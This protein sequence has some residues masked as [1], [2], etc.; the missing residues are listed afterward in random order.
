MRALV[1]LIP[2]FL[3]AADLVSVPNPV[4]LMLEFRP[5]A[6]GASSRGLSVS[7]SGYTRATTRLPVSSRGLGFIRQV[8]YTT[9]VGA[10]PNCVTRAEAPTPARRLSSLPGA[11]ESDLRYRRVVLQ[12]VWPGVDV[13]YEV[14]G[15]HGRLTFLLESAASAQEILLDNWAFPAFPPG[16]PDEFRLFAEDV[17]ATLRG[18]AVTPYGAVD[19]PVVSR[20]GTF[21]LPANP[22]GPVR[23]ILEADFP[24]RYD[25]A[26]PSALARDGSLYEVEGSLLRKYSPAGALVYESA[27][28]N[29]SVSQLI[30]GETI[31]LFGTT[32]GDTF[33]HARV[34][35]HTGR[36]LS[37]MT[38][39]AISGSIRQA[40]RDDSGRLRLIVDT[41]SPS[42]PRR[43]TQLDSSCVPYTSTNIRFPSRRCRFAVTITA[44]GDL[45]ASQQLPENALGQFTSDGTLFWVPPFPARVL[46]R[47]AAGGVSRIPLLSSPGYFVMAPGSGGALWFF[48]GGR[49]YRV[50]SGGEKVLEVSGVAGVQDIAPDGGG[51][52]VVMATSVASPGP[53]ALMDAP[54]TGQSSALAHIDAV[55]AVRYATYLPELVSRPSV[56]ALP[57]I[58]GRKILWR[59]QTLDPDAP[60]RPAIA[61]T[62]ALQE[63][64]PGGIGFLEVRGVP[65]ESPFYT[66][67]A[68]LETIPTNVRGWSVRIDGVPAPILEL[69][70]TR[71]TVIVPTS[72]PSAPL[73]RNG[74]LEFFYQDQ[75]A[76]SA[77]VRLVP[78]APRLLTGRL[79]LFDYTISNQFGPLTATTNWPTAGEEVRLFVDGSGPTPPRIFYTTG[80]SIPASSFYPPPG[81]PPGVYELRF[82]LPPPPSGPPPDH[83]YI[84][85]LRLSIKIYFK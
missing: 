42:F 16:P 72:L 49:L 29:V 36:F 19:T 82:V 21:F 2:A 24:P 37:T 52:I 48:E 43:G 33:N 62:N 70:R 1:F 69:N 7:C 44:D 65:D 40:I 47:Y 63:V 53:N 38:F 73:P 61:C 75:L 80:Q 9:F 6:S 76:Q 56:K 8:T 10:N 66:S 45:L 3:S 55:G 83:I 50:P 18:E 23:I 17:M 54:C 68:N 12:R 20:A 34:D 85:E 58:F 71:L 26:S 67:W 59:R 30:V 13:A 5:N 25:D 22:T 51:G 28:A 74:T 32:I 46:Q 27:F 78:P 4:G 64:T 14:D 79:G 11:P 57:A 60:S 39:S 35:P 15:W 77:A 84:P 81:H 31:E 41:L